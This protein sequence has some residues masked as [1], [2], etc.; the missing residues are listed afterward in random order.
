MYSAVT[1]AIGFKSLQEGKTMGLAPYGAKHDLK[2]FDFKSKFNGI[3][4][5]Y[6]NFC[7]EGCY[8]ITSSYSIQS[9]KEKERGAYEAQIECE[10]AL[11]HLANYTKKKLKS[12]KLCLSGGVALNSV[13]NN[14]IRSSKLFDDVF[15]NPAAS[16]T[17]I[18]LGAA[19][20]GLYE[21]YGFDKILKG[22][23]K[24]SPF[25]GPQYSENEIAK[26]ITEVNKD[27][28]WKKRFIILEDATF[29]KACHLLSQNFILACH[30]GRSEMGPRALGNRSILMSPLVAENKDRLNQR[31][32]NRENFRPFACATLEHQ[33]HNFFSIDVPS[34]YMLFV[35]EVIDEF[36][37][38]LPAITH[39]DGSVRLQT[40]TKQRNDRFYDLVEEFGKQ[41]GFPVILNTS[42]NVAGEPIVE[43]PYDAIKCFSKTDIDALLIGDYLLLKNNLKGLFS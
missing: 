7:A 42:F 8:K 2:I 29:E 9:K 20:Y 40:L 34:P 11:M 19:L 14:I 24:I 13:A 17:G 23:Q 31:V 36:K 38:K 33:A 10:R 32:K 4:T 1:Q 6:S 21:L 39:V 35:C 25:L 37:N 3:V 12:S 27:E 41:T 18:A 15:I 16:D 28:P 26:S 22:S 30:Q 43:T 5:D